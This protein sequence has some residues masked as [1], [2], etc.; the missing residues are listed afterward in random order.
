MSNN[1]DIPYYLIS[2]F[3]AYIYSDT[4]YINKEKKW[5]LKN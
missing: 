4:P 5:N 3:I 2:V 1:Q